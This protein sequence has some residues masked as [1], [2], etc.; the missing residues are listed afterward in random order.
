[1]QGSPIK[2]EPPALAALKSADLIL[3]S[4]IGQVETIVNKPTQEWTTAERKYSMEV[5]ATTA[6]SA[7]ARFDEWMRNEVF[8]Y[9]A[10]RLIGCLASIRQMARHAAF[11][12]GNRNWGRA[13]LKSDVEQLK[14]LFGDGFV[15]DPDAVSLEGKEMPD[16]EIKT[17][18]KASSVTN[19]NERPYTI[20]DLMNPPW[21]QPSDRDPALRERAWRADHPSP[22]S[23][24]SWPPLSDDPCSPTCLLAHEEQDGS[25]IART[26]ECRKLER[27]AQKS[28]PAAPQK[29]NLW[30]PV[31]G[32]G[33]R[34][35]WRTGYNL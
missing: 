17:T 14:V 5:L 21:S 23:K 11:G 32:F 31:V 1:L 12:R 8:I 4:V 26:P 18:D 10:G 28:Q 20:N 29:R 15:L 19:P 2:Q 30:W 3:R 25:E 6:A 35:W 24:D 34:F 9:G 22:T 7:M 33:G 16:N 27:V 13:H